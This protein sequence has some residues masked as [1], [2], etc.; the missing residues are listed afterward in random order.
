MRSSTTFGSPDGVIETPIEE[1]AVA[2]TSGAVRLAVATASWLR[3]VGEFDARGGWHGV[4][5]ASCAHWLSWQ[6][7]LGPGAAREHVRVARALRDLPVIEA[8]FAEGRLSYSKVRA[9][10]RVAEPGTEKMLIE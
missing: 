5:I 7:G 9:I 8:A 3:L 6:C 1:L 10:T 2:I 4:G